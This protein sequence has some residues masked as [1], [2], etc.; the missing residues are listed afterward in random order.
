MRMAPS[1]WCKKIIN[2]LKTV[3]RTFCLIVRFNGLRRISKV[4]GMFLGEEELP[5]AL[6]LVSGKGF[7]PVF[8]SFSPVYCPSKE[9]LPGGA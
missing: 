1:W 7:L 8:F 5:L 3:L 9:T 6:W 2:I 4:D